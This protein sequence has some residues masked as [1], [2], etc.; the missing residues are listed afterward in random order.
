M[1]TTRLQTVYDQVKSLST[2]N[3]NVYT[4]RGG[5]GAPPY[6]EDVNV[7]G[8]GGS[9]T[10]KQRR[11]GWKDVNLPLP[12]PILPVHPRVCSLVRLPSSVL[13]RRH[14]AHNAP[15]LR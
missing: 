9:T 12:L 15:V 8:G 11:P 5:A 14:R 2:S 13:R 1:F 4:V 6:R 10:C 7:G 3:L